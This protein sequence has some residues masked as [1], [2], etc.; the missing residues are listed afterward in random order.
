V[1]WVRLRV[2]IVVG[3]GQASEGKVGPGDDDRAC[4]LLF[5]LQKSVQR[6]KSRGSGLG[7]WPS[8]LCVVSVVCIVRCI[9][10]KPRSKRDGRAAGG[11]EI[12]TAFA[13]FL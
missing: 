7:T 12:A 2:V 9:G 13:Q 6:A 4:L 5:S 10:R 1:V 8:E 11:H 3:V